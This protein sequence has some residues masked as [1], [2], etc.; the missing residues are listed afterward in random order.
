MVQEQNEA[1]HVAVPYGNVKQGKKDLSES[2]ASPT[3][4]GLSWGRS[5]GSFSFFQTAQQ[6]RPCTLRT[7]EDGKEQ[8]NA[9][10]TSMLGVSRHHALS[11]LTEG[12]TQSSMHAIT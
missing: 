11:T 4:L 9:H 7:K 2:I 12:E 1:S 8:R 3:I 5:A 6:K 10:S